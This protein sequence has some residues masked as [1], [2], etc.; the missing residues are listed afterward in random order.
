M[1]PNPL[2]TAIGMLLVFLL[3]HVVIWRL[4]PRARCLSTL[5]LLSICIL[6]GTAGLAWVVPEIRCCFPTSTGERLLLI[7]FHVFM[8][9]G[10][11]VGYSG[12]E[13]QS[14][15]LMI[16]QKVEEA[17]EAGLS[18]KALESLVD[19][20]FLV[21]RRIGPLVDARMVELRDAD[22]VLLPRGKLLAGVFHMFRWCTGSVRGG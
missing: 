16:L 4:L 18:V 6:L 19:D 17:G 14:P 9:L 7:Q 3:L 21:E 15:S 11:T 13:Q 8:T 10:Y 1:W 22:L 5:V 20:G 12:I 2:L